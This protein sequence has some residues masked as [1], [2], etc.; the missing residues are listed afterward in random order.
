MNKKP[1]LK[2]AGVLLLTAV[3]LLSATAVTANT[4]KNNAVCLTTDPTIS[5]QPLPEQTGRTVYYDQYDTDGSNGLSMASRNAF[6]Y[7]RA[8]MDD[9]VIPTGDTWTLT[10]FH[11]LALW[12]T[13]QPGSGTGFALEYW[14]DNGGTPGAMII[15]TTAS[16]YSET[17]TGR[18]WFGRAEFEIDYTYEPITLTAGTYWI[19][20]HI[21]GPENCFWMARSTIIGSE[22]WCDWEDYGFLP[23]SSIF[24]TQYDLTFQLTGGA[25][26]DTTPPVTHCSYNGTNPVTV[27]ITATDDMSGVNHTY[28]NLDAAGYLEYA[29]PFDVSV[30]GNHTILVYSVDKAGNSETPHSFNFNVAQPPITITI[31]K[32]L[33]ITATIKNTGTTTLTKINWTIKLTG[34]IIIIGKNKPGTIA[35]LA[36]A[37]TYN[38]KDF[39]LGF[40]K[41]NIVATAGSASANATGIVL[42]IIVL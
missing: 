19:W 5:T 11:A 39:V 42:I 13:L 7:Q 10:D 26:Q 32:G 25:P 14:S 1:Y 24:G 40:G 2:G 36:P 29:A 33:G 6:G 35:S 41:T 31:K 4:T 9:F 37:A 3:L 21:I 16:T 12:N 15:N 38:A 23:G 30:P 8:L 34:G 20:G 18:F 22:C 27:T 28:Y 17:A